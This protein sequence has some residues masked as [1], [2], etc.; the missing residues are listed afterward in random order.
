M[1]ETLTAG[2]VVSPKR[3]NAL[4][5]AMALRRER[6]LYHRPE[7]QPLGASQSKTAVPG[8]TRD[9]RFGRPLVY[10]EG[11]GQIISGHASD[12]PPVHD[13]AHGN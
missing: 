10:G 3:Q 7:H 1:R 2:D 12:T 5:E 9:L 4:L 13:H 6:Q 8:F 11:A